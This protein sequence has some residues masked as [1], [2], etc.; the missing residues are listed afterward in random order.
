MNYAGFGLYILDLQHPQL[1]KMKIAETV[2]EWSWGNFQIYRENKGV[3]LPFS[4]LATERKY[5]YKMSSNKEKA[6]HQITAAPHSHG[7]IYMF[8]TKVFMLVSCRKQIAI[9]TYKNVIIWTLKAP[10]P[11]ADMKSG[12]YCMFPGALRSTIG[13]LSNCVLVCN[14][15]KWNATKPNRTIL[16][17]E[18]HELSQVHI[19]I[20]KIVWTCLL[21]NSEWREEETRRAKAAFRSLFSPSN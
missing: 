17:K 4:P 10:S 5:R 9:R 14:L 20:R 21:C 1:I 7:C 16:V 12:D 18:P 11:P 3:L 6:H 19:L 13:K 15:S 2:G 8:N